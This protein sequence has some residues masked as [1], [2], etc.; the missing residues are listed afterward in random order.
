LHRLWYVLLL[1]EF[2]AVLI[3]NLYARENPKAW[4]IP[5]FYWYQ[6]AWIVGSAILTAIVYHFTTTSDAPPASASGV[7]E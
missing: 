4:G 7:S 3:P 2:L 5:F 6:F 1:V